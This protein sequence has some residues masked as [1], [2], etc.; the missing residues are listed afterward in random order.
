M[1]RIHVKGYGRHEEA[2][3]GESV[4]PGH[5]VALHAD[6]KYYKHAVVG[7]KC[8][9]IFVIEDALQGKTITDA[10]AADTICQVTMPRENDTVKARVAAGALAITKE[11]KVISAG[12][13]TVKKLVSG[14][15][16]DLLY[17]AIADAAALT[18][19]TSETAFDKSY[20]FPVGSLK[21]GDKIVIEGEVRA[22]ATNSTDTLT[23]KVKIG[24]TLLATSGAVDVANNDICVFRLTLTVTDVG[25]TGHF[26]AS[27]TISLGVAG[28]V[29]AKAVY[30]DSTAIDTTAT[31]AITVTGQWSNA[32]SSNSATLEQLSVSRTSTTGSNFVIGIADESVDNS[33]EVTEDFINIRLL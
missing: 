16:T 5:L 19:T 1:N 9:K 31:Q 25:A 2:Y 17:N 27:G 21:A 12:D 22:T 8:E 33:G 32:S 14:G 24:S 20:T 4:K 13:G 29:T 18:N 28:T 11:D 6:S 10:I 7:G 15:D 3:A 26:T 30:V 23:V